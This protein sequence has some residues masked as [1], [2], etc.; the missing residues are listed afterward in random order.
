[1]KKIFKIFS[2]AI[3]GLLLATSCNLNDYPVFNEEDSF[4]GFDISSVTV[5][6]DGGQI[7]IPVTLASVEG[8]STTI[9]Y[10]AIDSTAFNGKNFQLVDASGTLTFDSNNRTQNIVINIIDNP[11]VFTGDIVFSVKFKDTGDLNQSAENTCIVKITDNDHPLSYILGTYTC[12]GT[13]YYNGPTQWDIQVMKD[14]SDLTMVW[15]YNFHGIGNGW[16]GMD[17]LI[18]GVV[19]K[20]DGTITVPL[21]QESEYIYS[22]S[23]TPILF[24]GIDSNFN[25]HSSGNMI[26]KIQDGGAKLDYGTDYGIWSMIDGAGNLQVILPGITAVKQ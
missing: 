9:S 7:T 15:I 23:G 11:G 8:K 16:E 4:V 6:E 17:M 1:M 25:G 14:E 2:I 5:A 18:Y 24:L 10:E 19:N 3:C 21:G 26:I 13:S 22:A 12:S 20:E